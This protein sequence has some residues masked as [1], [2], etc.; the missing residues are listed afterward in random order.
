MK[1]YTNHEDDDVIV[2]FSE[3]EF[4]NYCRLL[5]ADRIK[6]ANREKNIIAPMFSRMILEELRNKHALSLVVVKELNDNELDASVYFGL[7][8]N[9]KS[10]S[11]VSVYVEKVPTGGVWKIS[12]DDNSF[13]INADVTY[14]EA[15]RFIE[16][17]FNISLNWAYYE[18]QP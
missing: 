3:E 4:E 9:G 17:V 15:K 6:K 2:Q 7:A 1:T 11:S 18:Q 5:D 13:F 10:R 12:L 16:D 8:A 14:D